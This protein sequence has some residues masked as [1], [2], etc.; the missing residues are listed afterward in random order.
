MVYRTSLLQTTLSDYE[1][2]FL[3]ITSIVSSW[4]I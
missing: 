3:N 1:A 2:H 4:S